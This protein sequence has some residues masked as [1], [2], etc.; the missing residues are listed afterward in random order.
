MQNDLS[1][2]SATKVQWTFLWCHPRHCLVPSNSGSTM[3]AIMAYNGACVPLKSARSSSETTFMIPW[4]S[5]VFERAGMGTCTGLKAYLEAHSI[6]ITYTDS[7][8]KVRRGTLVCLQRF[9]MCNG[10]V[11]AVGQRL[12]YLE[13]AA[14]P[15]IQHEKY[16]QSILTNMSPCKARSLHVTYKQIEASS[17]SL[18]ELANFQLQLLTKEWLCRF[19]KREASV[20][21]VSKVGSRSESGPI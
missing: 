20:Q 9:Y 19:S 14:G 10:K 3:A 5:S 13:W 16:P 4:I 17:Q 12:S 7:T 15:S 8:D 21:D 6:C 18:A 1:P 11:Y 2:E